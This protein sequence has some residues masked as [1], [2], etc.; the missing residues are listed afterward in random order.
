MPL[1]PPSNLHYLDTDR[2]IVWDPVNGASA[3]DI[4]LQHVSET[5]WHSNIVMHPITFL[6]FTKPPGLYKVKGRTRD[7][8]GGW[9]VYSDPI[10]FE[11]I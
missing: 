4:S 10:E 9:G 2:K 5:D 3:Y 7:G 11:V 1:P 6:D 8:G